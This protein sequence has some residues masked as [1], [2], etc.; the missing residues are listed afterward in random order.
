MAGLAVDG[1]NNVCVADARNLSSATLHGKSKQMKKNQIIMARLVILL[2]AMMGVNLSQAAMTTAFM[3]HGLLEVGGVPANGSYDFKFRIYNA[4]TL[5]TQQGFEITAIGIT[6]NN[7]LFTVQ[8]D[9]TSVPFGDDPRWLEIDA[10]DGGSG[11]F[12]TLSPRQ[13]FTATPYAIR[14]ANFSGTVEANQLAVGAAAANLGS[15]GQSGVASGGVVLSSDPANT[16]LQ[17]AG[18]VKIGDTVTT[19]DIWKNVNPSGAPTAEGSVV[20]TTDNKMIVW[21]GRKNTSPFFSNDGAIYDPATDT[22]TAMNTFGAPTARTGHKAVWTGSKMIVWGGTTGFNPVIYLNDG[23]I[24]DPN[25]D[26]WTPVTMTGA[27]APRNSHTMVRAGSKIIVWGGWSGSFA[28]N[29]G[30]IY[31]PDSGIWT[32][33]P[34]TGAP[35]PRQLHT[36]IWTGSKMIVWGGVQFNIYYNDGG[37]Y[38]PDT[39]TWASPLATSTL[40]PRISHSAVWTGSEM[41]IWGGING[42][43]YLNTGGRYNPANNSWKEMG[44]SGAPVARSGH[45]AVWTSS[46]MIVWGGQTGIAVSDGGRYNPSRD[47]WIGVSSSGAP[48]AVSFPR[49]VWTG[50]EMIVC[51]YVN[52]N[53][54]LDVNRFTPGRTLYLYQR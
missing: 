13:Q 9:F 18:Y 11:S 26:S 33:V 30:G 50:S 27:P 25:N 8:L 16:A 47:S 41:I 44:L 28:F 7:G 10:A 43:G 37:I 20:W 5:G 32:A 42:N 24:Y 12:T 53:G 34:T 39:G 31:D 54:I 17:N 1:L 52:S 23:G 3:Y 14:A 51:G 19:G 6:V 4:P 36:A 21:G 40:S 49:A 29:D 48:P 2:L 15:S 45:S 38:D 46:E 35:A 22:W